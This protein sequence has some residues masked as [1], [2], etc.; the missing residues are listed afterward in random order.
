VARW[1]GPL[2]SNQL[3]KPSKQT[4]KANTRWIKLALELVVW[5]KD[6]C[7]RQNKNMQII[8]LEL[9]C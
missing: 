5:A 6:Q 4:N 3:N 1:A 2:T 9:Q 8:S 7:C